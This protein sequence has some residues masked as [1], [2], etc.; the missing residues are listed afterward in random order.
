MEQN[1]SL[2]TGFVLPT[3]REVF[4]LLNKKVFIN[5]EI[6]VPDDETDR[7]RYDWVKAVR[8]IHQLVQ[9]YQLKDY[10]FVSSFDYAALKEMEHYSH[11]QMYSVKTIYLTNYF[12]HIE[13]PAFDEIVRMGDGLNV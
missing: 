13:V 12:N 10:C 1:R 2:E 4:D 9:E 5:I 6:K 11:S 8:V 7:Q 3:L